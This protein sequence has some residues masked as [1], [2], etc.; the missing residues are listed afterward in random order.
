MA[1]TMD[2]TVE[3]SGPIPSPLGQP[4]PPSSPTNARKRSFNEVDNASATPLKAREIYYPGHSE[5]QE[6]RAP[7]KCDSMTVDKPSTAGNNVS[8]IVTTSLPT[9]TAAPGNDAIHPQ[10]PSPRAQRVESSTL[11]ALSVVDTNMAVT[12]SST[13]QHNAISSASNPTKKRKLSPNSK[14]A[15]RLEKE[16]NDRL[17]HEEKAKKEEEKRIKEEEKKKREAE[18]EEERRKRDEK[19]KLKEEE[20]MAKDEERRKK[21][22]EK[23]KK[24]RVSDVCFLACP[25]RTVYVLTLYRPK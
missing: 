12:T 23:S 21:E 6:N 1:S 2:L 11:T 10:P 5:D 7:L 14:D 3:S 9:P 16:E 18:R 4:F 20:K 19:K 13:P 15:Q 24:E 25:C 22:E 17:K 8:S